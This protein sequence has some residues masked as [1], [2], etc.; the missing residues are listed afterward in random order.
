VRV[1][2]CQVAMGCGAPEDIVGNA[3]ASGSEKHYLDKCKRKTPGQNCSSKAAM[4]VFTL[5]AIATSAIPA[6]YD[7]MR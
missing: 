4:I 2:A 7:M 6:I 5:L 1:V 3:V